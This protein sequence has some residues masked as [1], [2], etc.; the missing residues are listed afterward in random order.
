MK[1]AIKGPALILVRPQMGE[2]IGAAAR[3]ML[4]FGLTDLRL[5]APR[6][7]WPNTRAEAMAAGAVSVI[8]AA[9]VTESLEE[10][11]GDLNFLLATTARPRRLSQPVLSPEEGT[12][13]IRSMMAQGASCGVLFG[14]ENAGLDNE[15]LALAD[16]FVTYPV[17]GDYSSV[18]LAQAVG[19]FAYAFRARTVS[20]PLAFEKERQ[21][22][23]QRARLG[24]LVTY[25]EEAL[26][27]AGFFFPPERE[28]S[29][30]RHLRTALT[31]AHWTD[32][33]VQTLYGALK[34]LR[35]IKGKKG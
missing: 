29:M 22:P 25:L 21:P 13:H 11:I 18:N 15:A 7:G 24:A 16:A 32:Q 28:R 35:K 6:D 33:Q 12:G 1:D 31:Q 10:A 5:V 27:D 30:K 14:P 19:I 2:N 4:N 23:A 17:A 20:K 8:R 26:E 34:A 3:A 9:R